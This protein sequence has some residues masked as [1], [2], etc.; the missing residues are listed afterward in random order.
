MSLTP[1]ERQAL[2]LEMAQSQEGTTAQQV[3]DRGS[4]K[5]D[6]VSP[7]AY[8]NLGRRLSHR[9]LLRAEKS[10]ARTL[11]FA[12]TD[13]NATWL[14]EELIASVID[15]EYPLPALTAYRE[16]LRQ[17]RDI[18]DEI[19]VEARHRLMEADARELF[20]SAITS[21]A[22]N[23]RCEIVDY[24]RER[25]KAANAPHLSKMKRSAD[26]TLSLLIGLCKNGL[27]LSMEALDLPISID[28]AVEAYLS[29]E[30]PAEHYY[31]EEK[32]RE[33]LSLRIEPGPMV[34]KT[35]PKEADSNLVIAGVDGS[36]VGGLLS[37]DGI[38]GDFSFGHA[39]QVSINTSTGVLN[40]KIKRGT[41]EVPAFL[42]LPEKPEDMQGRDNLY[43]IMAKMFYPDLTD[44]EYVH[45]AWN[46]MDLLECR[47]TLNLMR[48]WT[49]QPGSVEMPAS[50]VI[51][52][53]GTV[54]PNARESYP[55]G[56]QNAYGRI[57]RELIGA[58]WN[59]VK[60]CREDSQTVAGVVKNAQMRV[61][62]P[63]VNY[64]LC[65]EAGKVKETQIQTWPL[66]EM[67]ALLDQALMSRILTA[68]RKN[69]DP[70]LRTALVLRPFHSTTDFRKVYSRKK[71]QRPADQ[72]V[73]RSEAAKAKRVSE[74]TEED[75]WW[76]T[77]RVPG[78]PYLQLLNNAWYAGFYLGAFRRLDSSETLSRLEFVLPHS[79]EETGQFPEESCEFHLNRA[80]SALKSV[81]FDVDAQHSTYGAIGKIDLQP[82]I[83]ISAQETVK[84]WA[85]ELRDRVSEY[86]DLNLAKY[87]KP[88]ERVKLR[89][90]KRRDL[91]TWIET[92]QSDRKKIGGKK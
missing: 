15:P 54:V 68:A 30:N 70:W 41:A 6:D 35:D 47:T 65:Q 18:P 38:S 46:A 34:K 2:F 53:D 26:R 86:M 24:A 33:E 85:R 72:L 91:E 14:D 79:T 9:G 45:S 13:H 69:S 27:G 21:Y 32:L 80:L 44:S 84:T 19:W 23:L 11:Y 39:P 16:S 3:F 87:L 77:L 5:G 17:I 76:K 43:T 89:P 22:D 28:L 37:L 40:R 48:T 59:I 74:L 92:M 10:G 73:K 81:G 75:A 64:F 25:V 50:D 29:E 61:F 57:V 36:T 7:E 8:F 31:D 66:E 90:W 55:Y 88:G 49:M 71:G 52:R 56:Q 42:R 62:S 82:T 60:N 58:S 67:N 20:V 51:L 4:D 63:V 83:L 1:Q 12:K 78:D